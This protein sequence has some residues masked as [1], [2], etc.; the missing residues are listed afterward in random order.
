MGEETLYAPHYHSS[1]ALVVGIN[2]YRGMPPLNSAVKDAHDVA[3]LLMG[4][5][6]FPPE[7]V[8]LLTDEM[9]T[10][11]N[12]LAVFDMVITPQHVAPDD[13]IMVFFAGHG[14]TRRANDGSKVGYMAPVDAAPRAWRTLI[15]M[16]DLIDQ[17]KFLPAKHILF[18]MDACY[19]GL[20]FRRSHYTAPT[21]EH[22]LMHRAVQVMTAGREDEQVMDGGDPDGN[23]AFSGYLLDALSGE[24][25]TAT[26]LM[27]A[28]DV[29]GYVSRHIKARPDVRQTPQ[30]GWIEGDGD[31]VFKLPQGA[32]LPPRLEVTLRQGTVPA[33]LIALNELTGIADGPDKVLAQ[34]ALERLQ[35][36]A[37]SDP[38]PRVTHTALR[39]LG[40]DI[41]P[42]PA[43]PEPTRP[44]RSA[45]RLHD[46]LAGLWRR[47]AVIVFLLLVLVCLGTVVAGGAA[48]WR[49]RL[50]AARAAQALEEGQ[51]ETP[52]G[53]GATSGT[54]ATSPGERSALTPSATAMLPPTVPAGSTVLFEDDFSILN[55]WWEPTAGDGRIRRRVDGGEMYFTVY[56]TYSLWF[57][58]PRDLVPRDAVVS[59]DATLLTS[60]PDGGF[61]LVFRQIDFDNYYYY[62]VGT[63]G[64]FALLLQEGGAVSY[65]IRPS[66][67][68]DPPV[69]DVMHC[70]A[71]RFDGADLTLYYDGRA[72]AAIEN[73]RYGSGQVGLAVQTVRQAP[74]GVS[75]DNFVV[76]AP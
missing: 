17:A 66:A 7:Q 55:D 20:S 67:L 73:K 71:A 31:F 32:C 68:D 47:Y 30:Y 53:P 24:A 38:D 57:D 70:L 6:S 74:V 9:A 11:D 49:G 3:S 45:L 65:L 21:I 16:G 34:L 72:V 1:W 58:R 15:E 43:P 64:K 28:S 51:Q 33:R 5:H 36:V 69:E 59:V 44:S 42:P 25:A 29:M 14:L 50:A 40:I 48:V 2:A 18:I 39:L 63:D 19:S 62:R 41:P 54:P 12:I 37:E 8:I 56:G 75:F 26:N 61:G 35:E 46:R 60:Q 22:F 10:R 27:T 23:S 4:Y 52:A 13:R 76:Y